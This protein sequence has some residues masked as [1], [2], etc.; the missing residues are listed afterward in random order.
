MIFVG[1]DVAKD[2]HDYFITNSDGEVLFY[3]LSITNNLSGFTELYQNI[4]SVTDDVNKRYLRYAFYNAIKY[5]CHWDKS[6]GA[7]LEKKRSEGKH[8]DVA[9][10]HASKKLVRTI[11]AME[12]SGQPY[13]AAI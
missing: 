9:L 3:S 8:Y 6:F 5:V 4:L 1:I 13:I 11:F 10:S 12:K 7:Y 2:K